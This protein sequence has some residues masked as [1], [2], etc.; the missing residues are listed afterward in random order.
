M[1]SASILRSKSSPSPLR[2]KRCV[3]IVPALIGP[4]TFAT[5]DGWPVATV[6]PER[7]VWLGSAREVCVEGG[8]AFLLSRSRCSIGSLRTIA[9]ADD[10]Q[11]KAFH[12]AHVHRVTYVRLSVRG[13]T[14]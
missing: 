11:G 2:W 1:R 14:R 6:E 9:S 4:S 12:I 8:R 10:H 13:S 5:F 7:T 3:T